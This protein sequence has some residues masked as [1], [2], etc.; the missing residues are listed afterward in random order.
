VIVFAHIPLQVPMQHWLVL[1]LSQHW[2]VLAIG[3]IFFLLQLYLTWRFGSKMRRHLRELNRLR[4]DLEQ[5][6]HGREI[7]AFVADIPWLKWVDSNFPR[8]SAAPGNYTRD[9]VLKELDTQIASNGHYLLLQRAGIMAPLLGVILTMVGF[10][11]FRPPENESES[12]ADILSTVTPLVAG[13]GM[14]GV[15][16]FLNQWLLHLVG[17][18]AEKVRYAARS[19]FDA[20]IWSHVGL[21]VQAA[22]VKAITAMERMARAVT[23]T[24]EQQE[25]NARTLEASSEAIRQASDSFAQT[26]RAFGDELRALPGMLSELTAAAAAAVETLQTVVPAG[27]RAVTGFDASVTTFRAA[28]EN[29]FVEAAKIHRGVNEAL[30]ESVGRISESTQQLK[31]SSGDL[32]ETVNAH[33]NAF[34][35]LNRSLQKQ[36]LPAH[37][38]FLAAISQFNGRAEGVL[39]RLDSLHGE[40]VD[41]LERV[42][43]L[44]P[45]AAEAIAG[46]AASSTA[47]HDAVEHKFSPAAEEHQ[48]ST[49]RFSVAVQQLQKSAQGLAEGET[50]VHN[51]VRLQTR[52]S[53]ELGAVQE[54]LRLAVERLAETGVTLNQSLAA[55]LIPSQRT[56][57]QAAAHFG[58]SATRLGT[59]MEKGIDPVTRQLGHLDEL[60]G[61]LAGT[62]EAIG[63]FAEVGPELERLTQSLAQASQVTGAIAALPDQ[64]R[65]V[66]EEVAHAH[67]EQLAL[68]PRGGVMNWLRGRRNSA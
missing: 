44:A 10:V 28:V 39:E 31:V 13:V 11:M 33:T 66:L 12:F 27:Q 19:W 6:G 25:Q 60:L 64:L 62:V 41:S 61:R 53:E 22:T 52:L 45:Q 36:V 5:G 35:G 14:G 38:A 68:A 24:T 16:A 48:E 47:F 4:A 49:D 63:R 3:L 2:Y 54:T 67:Q 18:T 37:E 57:H 15:L 56:L 65:N 1:A 23:Q 7:E 26:H 8:D 30:H 9:D 58:D 17:R 40:L 43:S 42:A 51:L 50:V 29:Q 59:F 32:Q 55:E 46:F 34:K 20:A 21:D